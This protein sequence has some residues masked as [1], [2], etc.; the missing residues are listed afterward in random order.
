M[1][2]CRPCASKLRPR[3]PQ[4]ASRWQLGSTSPHHGL[5]LNAKKRRK[6]VCFLFYVFTT[7]PYCILRCPRWLNDGPK[8]AQ[9]GPKSR[10]D[11]PKTA[12]RRPHDGSKSVLWRLKFGQV[13][14]KLP[15]SCH[16]AGHLRPSCLQVASKMVPRASRSQLGPTWPHLGCPLSAENLAKPKENMCFGPAGGCQDGSKTASWRT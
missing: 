7:S 12:P 1:P 14:S 8:S 5:R 10:Q 4:E 16:L 15:P 13:A 2:S 11:G 3:W 6:T 9:G